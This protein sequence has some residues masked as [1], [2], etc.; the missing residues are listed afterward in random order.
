M[1]IKAN[2]KAPNIVSMSGAKQSIL[3]LLQDVFEVQWLTVDHRSGKPIFLAISRNGNL[4]ARREVRA[5]N[6][7]PA[8]YL[9]TSSWRKGKNSRISK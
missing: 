6:G 1:N 5:A 9:M 4:R 7:R 8:T 2:E 3:K